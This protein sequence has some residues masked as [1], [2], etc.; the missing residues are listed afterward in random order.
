MRYL[1]ALLPGAGLLALG[2]FLR[3]EPTRPDTMSP[4]WLRDQL[5]QQRESLHMEDK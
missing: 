3:R 2:W 4:E 1:L 5:D